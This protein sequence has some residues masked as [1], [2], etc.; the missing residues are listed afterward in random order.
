MPSTVA[1]EIDQHIATLSLT[2]KTMPPEFFAELEPAVRELSLSDTLRALIIRAQDP[3]NFCFG[4][5]LKAAFT[6][7]GSLLTGG[8]AGP[9]A[10]LRDHIKTLQG[11]FTALAE[12]PVP[13][14]AS[15]H[16]WCIGGGLDLISACDVRLATRDA[17]F[18]LRET[19]IA[20]VADLGSLQ[21]LP[22]IIGQG[23][24]REL[25]FTGKDIDAEHARRIGLVNELYND[26]AALDAAALAMAR[27]IAANPPLTVRGVKQ[28]LAFGQGR[29]P[30]EGLDYVATWNAAFLASEDLSEAVAAFAQKRPPQF[31]GR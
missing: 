5:D 10:R 14:I 15:V 2:G 12:C 19:K 25:A 28:V 16:G 21:R 24:T 27:D 31:R 30:A 8:L 23:H 29:T 18:S 17:R 9:R 4:L 22:S 11:S 7:D 20:I 1:V 3:K 26:R 13:V 6:G